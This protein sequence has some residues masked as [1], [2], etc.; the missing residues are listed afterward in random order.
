MRS[1]VQMNFLERRVC[2]DRALTQLVRLVRESTET[3]SSREQRGVYQLESTL[4]ERSSAAP[5][6]SHVFSG[7][8]SAARLMAFSTIVLTIVRGLWARGRASAHN[9][10]ARA[11]V[12][13]WC[14]VAP[15]FVAVRVRFAGVDARLRKLR[16]R[17]R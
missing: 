15:V 2:A 9:V 7:S 10:L 17:R 6:A 8:V 14:D 12:A 5:P 11:R 4:V 1:G 3:L 16:A 13:W